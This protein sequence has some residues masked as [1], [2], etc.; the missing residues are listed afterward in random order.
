MN[1]V[2]IYSSTQKRDQ[3]ESRFCLMR[4]Y[5]LSSFFGAKLTLGPELSNS[6]TAETSK[7]IESEFILNQ[8]RLFVAKHGSEASEVV[9]SKICELGE[10]PS[11]SLEECLIKQ[12]AKLVQRKMKE[13]IDDENN[14]LRDEDD[15]QHDSDVEI[16]PD[17]VRNTSASTSGSTSTF[18]SESASGLTSASG[19][20]SGPA[21]TAALVEQKTQDG[22]ERK[23]A[24]LKTTAK[25]RAAAFVED[26]AKE[27]SA[28]SSR[29]S[30]EEEDEN[31]VDDEDASSYDDDYSSSEDESN[32]LTQ[33]NM[34]KMMQ[35]QM[36]VMQAFRKA[37]RGKGKRKTK[38]VIR[39][40]DEE[41]D[42]STRGKKKN[43]GG[44]KNKSK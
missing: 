21:S 30:S 43:K 3:H 2:S 28:I 20:A 16:P 36:Q 44:K 7:E 38:R 40:D 19:S 10:T 24:R 29:S 32:L 31:P 39:S 41:D 25:R 18:A 17:D 35:M 6:F 5:T 1:I 42:R 34:K 11:N 12:S 22:Q 23:K 4:F 26:E 37:S 14:E 9:N 15:R 8:A 27:A 13:R 33:K